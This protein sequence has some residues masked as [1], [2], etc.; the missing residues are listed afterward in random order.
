MVWQVGLGWHF[1]AG[2]RSSIYHVLL[3]QPSA[4]FPLDLWSKKSNKKEN[5]QNILESSCH[6]VYHLHLYWSCRIFASCWT[7]SL[8]GHKWYCTCIH[9]N[10]SSCNWKGTDGSCSFLLDSSES[11]PCST[12]HILKFISLEKQQKSHNSEY[13]TSIG[14][15]GYRTILPKCQQLLRFTGWNSRSDDGRWFP[16]NMLLQGEGSSHIKSKNNSNI[17]V[18]SSNLR[19]VWCC[20]VSS[21][22]NLTPWSSLY[23]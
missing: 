13:C 1:S 12:S 19:H 3:C 23:H 10:N 9:P 5:G 11:V 17:H 2:S 18:N 21:C 14:G 8:E 20:F 15:I 16:S 7:Y 6:W 4:S 22:S